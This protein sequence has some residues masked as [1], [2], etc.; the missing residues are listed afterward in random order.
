VSRPAYDAQLTDEQSFQEMIESFAA[1]RPQSARRHFPRFPTDLAL[2]GQ[3]G[4]RDYDGVLVCGAKNSEKIVDIE[5]E[6]TRD[7]IAP[8][9]FHI[10]D[11]SERGFQIQFQC[12]DIARFFNHSL[13]IT[14]GSVRIPVA[15]SWCRQS[16]PIGRG[17]VSFAEGAE[18]N[19]A[20]MKLISRIGADS[21]RRSA[22][23]GSPSPKA[24]RETQP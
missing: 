11:F 7:V 6:E 9:G 19:P 1:F 8:K 13:F 2:S 10:V 23:E 5:E 18:G 22:G 17:G 16:P 24:P 14:I 4:A 12:E 3:L 15:F 20:L 21:R